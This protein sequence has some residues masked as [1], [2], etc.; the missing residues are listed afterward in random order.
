MPLWCWLSVLIASQLHL[1]V[2]EFGPSLR[3]AALVPVRLILA[4]TL[5]FFACSSPADGGC[6][7]TRRESPDALLLKGTVLTSAGPLEDGHLLVESGRITYV[8]T[9]VGLSTQARKATIVDCTGSVI[10]PGFIKRTST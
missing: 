3:T 7:V 2:H 10:S 6:K 8:G 9:G 4:S 1:E 5:G